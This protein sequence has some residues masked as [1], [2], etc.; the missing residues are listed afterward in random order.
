MKGTIL[1]VDDDEMSSQILSFIL[2]DEGY[3]VDLAATGETGVE[4]V[5]AKSYDVVFLDF[6][7][8]DMKGIDAASKMKKISPNIKIV[9]LTGYAKS[10][11]DQKENDYER[12]LLKPVPPE[13]IIRTIAEILGP[14]IAK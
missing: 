13:V 4:K 14:Q 5:S 7:L 11:E 2:T 10:G 8:P 1:L 12:V 9:L 3:E 6:Y